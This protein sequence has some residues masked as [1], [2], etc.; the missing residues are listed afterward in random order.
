MIK[1]GDYIK[2]NNKIDRVEEILPTSNDKYMIYFENIDHGVLFDGL[3]DS[4]V[5][6]YK[7]L[8]EQQKQRADR[9]EKRWRELKERMEHDEKEAF[10]EGDVIAH[11]VHNYVLELME[12][13]EEDGE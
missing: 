9:A 6:D 2:F 5:V 8:Y 12:G 13:L 10:G 3:Y 1:V 4:R 11:T 7:Q